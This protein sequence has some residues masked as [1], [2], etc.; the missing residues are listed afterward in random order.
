MAHTWVEDQ[1]AICP[2]C[3]VKDFIRYKCTD[4][5]CNDKNTKVIECRCARSQ[6]NRVTRAVGG[7]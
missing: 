6:D 7:K 3:H 1:S 5:W 2:N 4:K